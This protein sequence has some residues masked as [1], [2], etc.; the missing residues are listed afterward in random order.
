MSRILD[1]I[2][3]SVPPQKFFRLRRWLRRLLNL[4]PTPEQMTEYIHTNVFILDNDGKRI[5]GMSQQTLLGFHL[6]LRRS[7]IT[8]FG[9]DDPANPWLEVLK[10]MESSESNTESVIHEAVLNMMIDVFYRPELDINDDSD[11]DIETE[12]GRLH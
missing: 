5:V 1:G 11:K 10:N 7:L 2:R 9:L 3:Y 8:T 4:Y 6:L 12:M